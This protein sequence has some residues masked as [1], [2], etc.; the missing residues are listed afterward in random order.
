MWSLGAGYAGVGLKARY[1][2]GRLGLGVTGAVLV[3]GSTGVILEPS[4]VWGSPAV[5]STRIYLAPGSAG[6]GLAHEYAGA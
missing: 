2:R 6:A 3:P 5:R 1:M 4:S